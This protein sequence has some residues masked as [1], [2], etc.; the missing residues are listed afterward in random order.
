M[1]IIPKIAGATSIITSLGDIHKTALL[2]SKQEKNKATG[3]YILAS[4]I[5]N[6]K[7]DFVSFKDAQRKNWISGQHLFVS[8]DEIFAS[9]KGYFKGVIQGIE[10]YLP[11][12][13]LAILAIIPKDKGK[14]LSY[15]STIALAGVE[16]WDFL[17][18]GTGLFE[19]GDYLKR[20]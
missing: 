3:N 12:F 5:A 9:A 19:K 6:Q 17:K 18:N 16:I 20:K 4:S 1:P 10:R 2:Y 14:K 8:I 11:K 7:A 15:I 13:A